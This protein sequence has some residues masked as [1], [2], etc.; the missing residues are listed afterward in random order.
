MEESALGA[1]A[2]AHNHVLGLRGVFVGAAE[3]ESKG[4][5]RVKENQEY[6]PLPRAF[7]R[8]AAEAAVAD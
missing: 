4:G 7:G 2:S 6:Y 5:R 1:P 8:M 3:D